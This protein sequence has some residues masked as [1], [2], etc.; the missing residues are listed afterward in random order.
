MD[1]TRTPLPPATTYVQSEVFE[2]SDALIKFTVASI[3]PHY[4]CMLS[5]SYSPISCLTGFIRKTD[6]TFLLFSAT[7]T[8]FY[9]FA[10]IC[11]EVGSKQN[12]K[13]TGKWSEKPRLPWMTSSSVKPLPLPSGKTVTITWWQNRC[14]YLVAKPLPLPGSKT[15]TITWWQNHYLYLV[16]NTLPLPGGKTVTITWWQNRYLYLVANTLPLPGG[17]TITATW[18]QNRYHYL[19]AKPLRSNAYYFVTTN[20][21]YHTLIVSCPC[22]S[23]TN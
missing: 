9:T 22:V 12:K 15:V 23:P 1:K 7:K 20:T 2:H 3:P 8:L 11:S 10:Q 21:H 18:Q 17:K 4:D 13:K 6:G 19:M 16:A 14:L 5:V